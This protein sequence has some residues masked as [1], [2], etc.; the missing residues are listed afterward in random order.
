MHFFGPI[1]LQTSIRNKTYDKYDVIA[2][3]INLYNRD[4]GVYTP[5]ISFLTPHL[6]FSLF[7][8]L[9]LRYMLC[10]KK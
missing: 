9:S 6:A 4:G 3:N 2:V 10:F 7:I 8:K 1:P 5:P